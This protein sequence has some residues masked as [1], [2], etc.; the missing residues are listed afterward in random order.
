MCGRYTL[1]TDLFQIKVHFGVG[2]DPRDK[3]RSDWKPRF[4]IAPTQLAPIIVQEGNRRELH[5]ARF[6][7]IPF[8]AKDEKLA[9]S[10]INARAE[11][12][13]QKPAFRESWKRRRCIVPAD[14]FYEWKTIGRKKQPYRIQPGK[15]PYFAFAGLWDRWRSPQGEEIESFTIITS[16]AQTEVS[17]LHDRMPVI[18][19]EDPDIQEAWLDPENENLANLKS[20]IRSPVHAVVEIYPVSTNVNSPKNDSPQCIERVTEENEDHEPQGKLFD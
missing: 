16:D 2:A 5:L 4:N 9:H 13:D 1:T 20:L 6:G 11:S 14:G 18:L 17:Q 12:V 15:S 3:N 7:L 10:L 19:P 8:W